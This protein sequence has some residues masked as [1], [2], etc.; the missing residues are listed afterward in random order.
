MRFRRR[1]R[2][3]PR[4]ISAPTIVVCS[5]P[6]R[7]IPAPDL[8]V[9]GSLIPF[10]VLCGLAK[11]VSQTGRLTES[12]IERTLEALAICRAKMEARHVTRARLIATEACRI[13]ENGQEFIDHARETL[14]PR[15]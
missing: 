5:L 6:G 4:S 11:G 1:H 14:G 8:Q 12:A 2:L 13:A 9:S 15:T 10:P 3:L 7:L